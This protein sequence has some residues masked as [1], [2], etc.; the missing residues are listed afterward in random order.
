ML[1]ATLAVIMV[2][3]GCGVADPGGRQAVRSVN[4]YGG[5][6]AAEGTPRPG[7][8]IRLG[9]DREIVSF[10]PTR[11]NSNMAATAVYDSLLRLGPGGRVEPY[12]AESM[13]TADGGRTWRMT[14]RPGVRFSDGTPFDAAAVIVNT[15]RHVDKASSP[16]HQLT[17][18][19][20]GMR[21]PDPLTV[22]FELTRPTG[23]FAAGFAQ[24]F[25][26]GTLGMIV[27]PAALR[28]WGDQIGQ[29]PVGAGPFTLVSWVRDAKLVLRR[30]PDYW[31]PGRPYLDG[32]E[33]RPLPDTLSRYAAIR[34]GDV[35]LIFGG[36]IDELS[37]ALGR[38]D[39]AVY[40]GSG[41]GAEWLYY[42][43]TRPPFNDRRMREAVIRGLDLRALS[44][45]QYRNQLKPA[46][47]LF[48][49][50]MPYHSAAASD[51]WPTY[52]P[53]RAREL[54]AQYRRDGGDPNFTFKTT[55]APN[56]IAFGEF[57]QAQMAALGIAVQV[58][59]YDLAQFSSSVVQ[60]NDFQATGWVGGPFDSPYPATERLF[61]TG[62]SGNYGRYSNPKMDQLLDQAL[63]TSDPD[64]RN[65]LYQQV[66]LLANQD[67]VLGFY[68][69]GY[70]STVTRPELKGVQRYL[71]RDMFYATT[72]LDRG[73]S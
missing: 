15:Q 50:E 18:R 8:T 52:D 29:H 38:D 4:P 54:V 35:D 22:V 5:D 56:R 10:D 36:Y 32:L 39:L 69:V 21:A 9:E 26:N 42:N 53:A 41:N 51:I 16:A 55:N 60:S 11:Q 65:R 49:A 20:A 17:T 68:S 61:H 57:V 43:F 30:N 24:S 14:L 34:N 1:A 33:F 2:A 47:S 67:L 62:G 25:T 48:G 45:S 19:I 27:S 70:L 63:S 13:T 23:E 3:T 40:Y 72:W 71:S 66:E 58:R 12:L 73:R 64:Q 59:Y 31:Q 6:P 7:G 46:T 37:R 28:R 44:A